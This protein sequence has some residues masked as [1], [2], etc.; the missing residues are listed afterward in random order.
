M[1]LH[2]FDYYNKDANSTLMIGGAAYTYPTY[3]LNKYQDKT[4]DVVEIDDK[5]TE[6][7]QSQFGLDVNNP[8]LTIYHQDGRSF[9]NSTENKYDTILQ[10]MRTRTTNIR[11][12]ASSTG[13][14]RNGPPVAVSLFQPPDS[15]QSGGFLRQNARY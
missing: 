6:L 2:L 7:A 11:A 12:S 14:M 9:L 4:I 1:I 13:I 15:L 5:M 10:N 3:Y 8:R